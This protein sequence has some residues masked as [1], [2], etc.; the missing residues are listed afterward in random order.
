MDSHL[1]WFACQKVKATARKER[2]Q[3][4]KEA[5]Q[6][7]SVACAA[8][9]K[10]CGLGGEGDEELPPREGT[11]PIRTA[12]PSGSIIG[13]VHPTED[14]S[15]CSSTPTSNSNSTTTSSTPPV[16]LSS[17]HISS[18]LPKT[19]RSDLAATK[20]KLRKLSKGVGVEGL[21]GVGM[22]GVGLEGLDAVEAPRM[23]VGYGVDKEHGIEQEEQEEQ[24]EFGP[25]S[26][27]SSPPPTPPSKSPKQISLSYN[28]FAAG[29]GTTS[30]PG[31]FSTT[32]ATTS[33]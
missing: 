23:R 17:D 7:Q 31:G 11:P 21:E 29:T 15:S 8:A 33:V 5:K 1:F 2:K 18:P 9:A 20:A 24:E 10:L 25:L 19:A 16:P 27:S 6:R 4:R 14:S 28:P 26:S 12:S 3:R 13:S 32:T 30:T 22:K